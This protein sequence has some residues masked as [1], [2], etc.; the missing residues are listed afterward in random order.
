[1]TQVITGYG[2]QIVALVVVDRGVSRLHVASG[3][4]FS[5]R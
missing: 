4:S 2:D 1:M 3:T 5:H